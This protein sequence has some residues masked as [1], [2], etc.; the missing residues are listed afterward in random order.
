MN[1]IPDPATRSFTVR[2]TS[3]SWDSSVSADAGGDMDGNAADVVPH[4]LALAGVQ[5]DANA[6]PRHLRG[7]EDRGRAA[8]RAGRAVERREEAVPGR[9]HLAA[10]ETAQGLAHRAL[11][12]LE[13][14]APAPITKIRGRARR[15]DDVGEEH[16]GEN[17]VGLG[18]ARA[19]VRNSCTSPSHSS[20]PSYQKEWSSPSNSTIRAFG[21]CSASQRPW[22]TLTRRSRE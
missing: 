3:S 22:R 13:Q 5:A 11:V 15:I 20:V 18:T 14:L 21:M 2:E 17:P 6:D 16:R 9:L 19:P 7:P 4:H 1:S 10:V 12:S 8:D